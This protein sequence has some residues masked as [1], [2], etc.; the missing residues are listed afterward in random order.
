[1]NEKSSQVYAISVFNWLLKKIYGT[2]I[3]I[4]VA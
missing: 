4:F 1:M 2:K 3:V